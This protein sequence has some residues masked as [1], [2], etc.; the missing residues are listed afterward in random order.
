MY[1]VSTLGSSSANW[2]L[3]R[4]SSVPIAGDNFKVLNGTQNSDSIWFL[5]RDTSAVTYGT[6]ELNW[7]INR[8]KIF[9]TAAGIE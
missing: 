4:V 7:K 9:S 6:T 1:Y 2:V 8:Y 3:S 5:D